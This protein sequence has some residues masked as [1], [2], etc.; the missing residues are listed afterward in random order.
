MTAPLL[1][2]LQNIQQ[3]STQLLDCLKQEKLALEENQLQQLTTISSQKQALL[4]QLDQLD[5]QR[6]STSSAKNFNK[7]IANSGNQALIKQ[8]EITRQSIAQC[9]QQNEINGRLLQKKQQLSSEMLSLLG[10]DKETIP[11]TYE[12]DGSQQKSASILGNTQA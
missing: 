3:H 2:L 10:G 9:Q 7:F 12:A 4:E 5:K 1:S 11:A 6:A 8:W